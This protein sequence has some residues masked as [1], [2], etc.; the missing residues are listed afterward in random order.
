MKSLPRPLLIIISLA[1]AYYTFFIVRSSFVLDGNRYFCLFDDAMISMQYAKNLALGNG[2]TWN[3]HELIEG[4]TNP[5]WTLIMSIPHSLSVPHNFT[6]LYIQCLGAIVLIAQCIIIWKIAEFLFPDKRII[7]II[8]TILTAFYV[9]LNTWALMGMEVS[10]CSLIITISVYGILKNKGANSLYP[11]YIL[12]MLGTFIRMDMCIP[13]C[14]IITGVA[15]RNKESRLKH[16]C[17]G[18]LLLALSV[19]IQTIWRYSYYGEFLPNTYY[20]KMTGLNPLYRITRGLFVSGK[21][22]LFFNPFLILLPVLFTLKKKE[23]AYTLI[24][25]LFFTQIA[26]STYVGGD[27]W[28]WWGGANRYISIA[29]APFFIILSASI[30]TIINRIIDKFH[31]AVRYRTTIYTITVLL[32]LININFQKDGSSIATGLLLNQPFGTNDNIANVKVAILL[33]NSDEKARVATVTAGAIHYFTDRTMYDILG[34]NDTY[35]ARLHAII[36]NDKNKYISFHPG[37]NKYDY[38]HSIVKTKPDFI[39]GLDENKPE[40]KALLKNYNRDSIWGLVLFSKK[41]SPYLGD[42]EKKLSYYKQL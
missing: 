13:A 39:I 7:H 27:A 12:L 3:A 42:Y 18:L 17:W 22:I 1:T 16:L 9:P 19:G 4:I 21:F 30:Y 33:N 11:Y 20:L 10:L 8:S 5:L 40:V 31:S 37:H 24:L 25:T 26:Y 29:I 38:N 6:S 2:L 34:K 36:P 15:L 23:F 14:I 32:L 35:I 41:D 28:D